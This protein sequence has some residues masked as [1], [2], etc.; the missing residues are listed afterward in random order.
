MSDSSLEWQ[1]Q[2]ID[3]CADALQYDNRKAAE[4]ASELGRPLTTKEYQRFNI[5]DFGL[6]TPIKRLSFDGDKYLAV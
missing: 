4:L 1:Q 3:E 5:K 2:H 6:A